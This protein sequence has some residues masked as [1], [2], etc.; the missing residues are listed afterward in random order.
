MIAREY[1][2][3]TEELNVQAHENLRRRADLQQAEVIVAQMEDQLRTAEFA[4]EASEKQKSE[5]QEYAH[6]E[7]VALRDERDQTRLL[8]VNPKP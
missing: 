4:H 2:R 1:Q 8:S 5:V 7:S 6:H 3:L